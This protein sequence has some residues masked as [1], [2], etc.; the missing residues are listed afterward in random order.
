MNSKVKQC[1]S[2]GED[3]AIS[4]PTGECDHLYYPE[5]ISHK[6]ILHSYSWIDE[7]GVWVAIYCICGYGEV[8]KP[9]FNIDEE[10]FYFNPLDH[11]NNYANENTE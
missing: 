7:T 3:I 5:N 9:A 11:E 6:H 2:C 10:T 8:V 1:K 4:N